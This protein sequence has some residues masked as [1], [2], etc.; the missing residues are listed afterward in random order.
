MRVRG[1]QE[2]TEAL[3]ALPA[4]ELPGVGPESEKQLQKTGRELVKM[5][6]LFGLLNKS[7]K[8]LYTSS[9]RVLIWL[10]R[11]FTLQILQK[12]L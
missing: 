11:F 5:V 10:Y 2:T 4:R 8:G 6:G 3:A 9:Y 1:F 12:A 7:I